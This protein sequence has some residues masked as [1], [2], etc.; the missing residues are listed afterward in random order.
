MVGGS[1]SGLLGLPLLLRPLVA[2]SLRRRPH[3]RRLV[4]FGPHGFGVYS[5]C[6]L[7]SK[8]AGRGCGYRGYGNLR[9]LPALEKNPVGQEQKNKNRDGSHTPLRDDATGERSRWL[10]IEPLPFDHGPISGAAKRHRTLCLPICN[11]P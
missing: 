8:A 6:H 7:L 10:G 11:Q 1:N 9:R 3:L 2:Q 4:G 5:R